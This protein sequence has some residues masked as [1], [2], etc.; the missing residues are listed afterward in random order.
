MIYILQIKFTLW[1]IYGSKSY[2]VF[3]YRGCLTIL[4]VE[5]IRYREDLDIVTYICLV[6]DFWLKIKFGLQVHRALPL[7]LLLHHDIWRE[8]SGFRFFESLFLLGCLAAKVARAFIFLATN[9]RTS[10]KCTCSRGVVPS[11]E[12]LVYAESASNLIDYKSLDI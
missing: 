10:L 11:E 1:M 4:W 9:E 6:D 5:K 2:S 12:D 8:R 3:I 7:V